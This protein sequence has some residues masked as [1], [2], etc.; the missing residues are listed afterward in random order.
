MTAATALRLATGVTSSEDE[1]EE[2]G[3]GS[4]VA[5]A[6]PRMGVQRARRRQGQIVN[7]AEKANGGADEAEAEEDVDAVVD[8]AVTMETQRWQTVTA[9]ASQWAR[10]V[11]RGEEDTEDAVVVVDGVVA[12]AV[13]E[14]EAEAQAASTAMRRKQVKRSVTW[15]M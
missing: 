14:A 15:V 6:H 10:R 8:E 12:E 4:G 13:G 9:A 7:K 11:V 3:A 1:A 5:T 2:E